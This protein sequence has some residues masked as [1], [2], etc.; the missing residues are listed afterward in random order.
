MLAIQIL[1][2]ATGT[3]LFLWL[4]LLSRKT[5]Q[6]EEQSHSWNMAS[7]SGLLWNLGSLVQNAAILFGESRRSY[8]CL[9]S[10]GI[11][12]TGLAILPTAMLLTLEAKQRPK[13]EKI[14][15]YLSFAVAMSLSISFWLAL[16][17]QNFP[18]PFDSLE[19]ITAYN[20]AF[21]VVVY[22]TLFR[23]KEKRDKR[24][25]WI[26]K[27]NIAL[28][29]LLAIVLMVLL[30]TKIQS[31]LDDLVGV[32]SQQMGIPIAI[33]ALASFSSFRFADV[34]VKRSLVLLSFIAVAL[35]YQLA[36]V[37]PLVGNMQSFAKFP[38]AAGWIMTAI[39]W[40]ILLLCAPS[41]VKTINQ[42]VDRKLFQRSDFRVLIQQ[43][44]TECE[45]VGYEEEVFKLTEELVRDVLRVARVQMVGKEEVAF[46][47]EELQEEIIYRPA[48][49]PARKL[50]GESE[51]ELLIPI[52]TQSRLSVFLA[53]APGPNGGRLLSDE[54]NFLLAITERVGRK[55]DSIG[56]KRERHERELRE[57][58]LQRL[59]TESELKALRAQ[60]NPHFLF[61]TLNTI[62]DLIG[63]EPEKAE[64]M[65]ER[66]A[67]V[68]RFVLAQTE[69]QMIGVKDE[70]DFLRTYLEIEQARF[71]ERLKVEIK[72]NQD[73][74]LANIPALILQPIVENA[75]KHGLSSKLE[76][77]LIRITGANEND[78]IY[79][80]VQD[81]GVGKN[82][83]SL[84]YAGNINSTRKGGVGLRNVQ[85]RLKAL[86][87]ERAK[88]DFQ[89]QSGK[90][91]TVSIWIPKDETQNVDSGRRTSGAL[92]LAK[93]PRSAHGN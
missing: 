29:T 48:T 56:F 1:G 57:S 68:F 62:A 6:F 69:Q 21:H 39:L 45:Q 85:E 70:F 83:N 60:I 4:I 15:R 77:G 3:I 72:L 40:S 26:T 51:I 87:G 65:T 82:S 28:L 50:L 78:F 2:F 90:G 92:A 46:S 9:V 75:I 80:K 32:A 5:E 41:I 8:I 20:L 10:L 58:N 59:L 93:T 19:R 54:L 31:S 52:R 47:D 76:G 67:E 16:F 88:I 81:D 86:Y 12:W 23:A 35:I 38:I 66:L 33:I 37:T 27:A 13:L 22:L 17:R 63:S 25:E 71:G 53:I 89:S 7:V 84:F 18:F 14:T 24:K 30:N 55:L 44:A 34:F 42:T 79:L 74:A 49:H 11:A 43:F 36:I 64:V 73:V 61:N 91:T